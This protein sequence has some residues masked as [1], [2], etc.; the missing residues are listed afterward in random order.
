LGIND[1]SADT[2]SPSTVVHSFY[3]YY[4]DRADARTDGEMTKGDMLPYTT[5]SLADSYLADLRLDSDA[6]N[7]SF[8]DYFLKAQDYGDS[9]KDTID[10]RTIYEDKTLAVVRC[11]MGK[12]PKMRATLLVILKPTR[13]G[14]RIHEV[15]DL[16]TD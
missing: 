16:Y 12:D 5:P 10:A 14:W 1:T 7:K 6:P 2:L 13:Q 3:R 4:L 15:F 11:I 9:W 8:S